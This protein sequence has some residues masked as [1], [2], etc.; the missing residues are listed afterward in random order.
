MP[1]AGKINTTL[2]RECIDGKKQ[3]DVTNNYLEN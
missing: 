2:I 1:D 3:V